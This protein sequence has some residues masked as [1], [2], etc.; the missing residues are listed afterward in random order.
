MYSLTHSGM[1]SPTTVRI[2][3]LR[4]CL[5]SQL[6]AKHILGIVLHR[7][8][9]IIFSQAEEDQTLAPETGNG[10]FQFA[11]ANQPVPAGGFQF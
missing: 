5:Q 3:L 1:L 7:L 9:S 4:F 10:A 8:T 11:P 2:P 6:W